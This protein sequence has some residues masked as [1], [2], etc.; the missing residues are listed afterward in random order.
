MDKEL[1]EALEEQPVEEVQPDSAVPTEPEVPTEPRV[2]TEADAVAAPPGLLEE[3]DKRKEAEFEARQ[4]RQQLEHLTRQE[5]EPE[6]VP[7]V[8]EEPEK[9]VEYMRGEMQRSQASTAEALFNQNLNWSERMAV[10]QHGRELTEEVKNWVITDLNQSDPARAQAIIQNADPYGTAIQLYQEQKNAQQFE[11]MD[12]S[13]IAAFKAF[14]AQQ[15][16]KTAEAPKAPVA[17]A[18]APSKAPSTKTPPVASPEDIDLDEI[19]GG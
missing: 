13:Q 5:P 18:N 8:F 2:P 11:G 4:L 9:F 17:T 10:Q 14:L 1:E 19:F 6:K 12:A 3:R 7:D 16:G 15:D